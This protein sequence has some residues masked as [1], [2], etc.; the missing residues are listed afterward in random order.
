M[1]K[2]P[3]SPQTRTRGGVCVLGGGVVDR[4]RGGLRSMLSC[5][6]RQGE[7]ERLPGSGPL[8]FFET[9]P[10]RMVADRTAGWVFPIIATPRSDPQT[11]QRPGWER[12]DG[13]SARSCGA[14]TPLARLVAVSGPAFRRR[15]IVSPPSLPRPCSLFAL[16]PSPNMAATHPPTTLQVAEQLADGFIALTGEYQLLADQH[17]E[18]ESKLSWAKQQVRLLISY[19]RH[20]HSAPIL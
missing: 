15:L 4:C 16:Q 6:L 17:R 12:T 10:G 1:N 9:R 7:A 11:L 18:L 20:S 19:P 8:L 2:P 14:N 13:C 3:H 5:V